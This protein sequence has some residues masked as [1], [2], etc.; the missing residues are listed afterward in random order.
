MI[1]FEKRGDIFEST[2]QTLVCPVNTVGALGKGMAKQ[3]KE[4]YPG[5]D[6]PYRRA[7]FTK[8]F[9]RDG[10][11]VWDAGKDDKVLCLPTKMHWRDPSRLAW[12]DQ[13]L[14]AVARDWEKHGLHSMAIPAVGCGEGGLSWD[15]VR[16]LIYEHFG[17]HPLHVGIFTPI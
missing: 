7:C 9:A 10:F 13:A 1:V 17:K 14:M 8:V 6:G 11:F 5:L 12:V 2:L 4:H 15:N 16:P 3:F